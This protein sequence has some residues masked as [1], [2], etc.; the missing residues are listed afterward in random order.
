[1]SAH[2]PLTVAPAHQKPESIRFVRG[3]R[4]AWAAPAAM[5]LALVTRLPGFTRP[6][7]LVFDEQYYVSNA[8]DLI[9]WGSVHGRFTQPPLGQWLIASGIGAFGFD[10]FGWRIA[11]LIAGVLTVGVV[12]AAVRRLT[13]DEFLAF[14]AAAFCALD[15]VMFTMG[16]IGMLDVFVGLFVALAVWGMVVL[17]DRA[18]V[19]H[20]RLRIVGVATLVAAGG[21]GSVKWFAALTIPVVLVCM[22]IADRRSLSDGGARRRAAVVSLVL[23]VAV[24]GVVYLASWAPQQLGPDAWS[25]SRFVHTHEHVIRFHEDLAPKNS[26]AAP[27]TTWFLVSRPT[28]LFAQNCANPAARRG[29]GPC[30]DQPADTGSLILA[31]PNPMVWLVCL[32]SL[33]GLVVGIVRRRTAIGV[34][35]L[36][37]V[38]S[39]WGPWLIGSRWAYTYYLTAII[40]TLLI[41][42]AW[43]I[44]RK[45]SRRRRTILIGS[46]LVT[47]ALFVFFYPVWTGHALSNDQLAQRIWWWGW[48]D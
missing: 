2:Q 4:R 3:V 34:A 12:A 7:F 14:W 20:R 9:Q 32:A 35:L 45:R 16:R 24:P 47:G 30:H 31:L 27:A 23:A 25:P 48:P 37:V 19:D 42:A 44:G 26:N 8:A 46:L 41:A 39:Q 15:G 10:P 40:P 29:S 6:G 17:L 13:R 21:A 33:A 18:V 43:Q 1:M 5:L 36:A 11:S 22:V 38:A 28:R